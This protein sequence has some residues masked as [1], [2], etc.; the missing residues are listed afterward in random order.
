MCAVTVAAYVA[1]PAAG[2]SQPE[3]ARIIF[4]HV[5]AAISC[6]VF[7]AVGTW[8]AIKV[9]ARRREADDVRSVAALEMGTLMCV[10]AAVTGSLFAWIQWGRPWHWDPRETSIV[11]QLMIYAAYFALRLSLAQGRRRAVVSAG[12][13]VFAVVT[14]P[15]LIF[16]LPRLGMLPSLHPSETLFSTTGLDA[17]YRTILLAALLGYLAVGWIITRVRIQAGELLQRLE[18][19]IGLEDSGDAAATYRLVRT[20]AVPGGGAG[21]GVPGPE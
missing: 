11:A 3:A 13:A 17:T 4:F 19:A 15:F 16:I 10:L 8:Y 6:V 7:F 5:P 20:D 14:V 12:Y 2:F 9:L 18:D 21:P 1:P